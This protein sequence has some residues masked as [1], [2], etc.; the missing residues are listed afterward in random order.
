MMA[1]QNDVLPS[2]APALGAGNDVVYGR[3]T[4]AKFDPTILALM[5]VS[6]EEIDAAERGASLA[7][8]DKAQQ[9]DHSRHFYRQ[10]N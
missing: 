4:V 3:L 5:V 8:L 9:S 2:R 10:R 1:G 6:T 7:E